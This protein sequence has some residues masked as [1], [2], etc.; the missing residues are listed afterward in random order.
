[1][2][3]Q[4]PLREQY[5]SV[6]VVFAVVKSLPRMTVSF[7]ASTCHAGFFSCVIPGL[8]C[9]AGLDPASQWIK[10]FRETPAILSL[11]LNQKGV[12]EK[13]ELMRN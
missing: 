5:F 4:C 1:M 10:V 2:R 11:I 3:T 13:R 12:Q 6:Y 9:H 8:N 7:R